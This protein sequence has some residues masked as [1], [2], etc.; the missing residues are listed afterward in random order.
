VASESVKVKAKSVK[1][2]SFTVLRF[3]I[4]GFSF[5]YCPGKA[6]APATSIVVESAIQ[7]KF[8]CS[9]VAG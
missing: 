6:Q 4:Y 8:Y 9:T 5:P 7:S 1:L 2:N 3:A